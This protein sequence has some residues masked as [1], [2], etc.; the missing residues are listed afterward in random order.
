MSIHAWQHTRYVHTGCFLHT[1][2]HNIHD[3]CH[4]PTV[5][6]LKQWKYMH[7]N[8]HETCIHDVFTYTMT[9]PTRCLLY[10]FFCLATYTRRA[11]TMFLH[12]RWHNLHDV[13][14]IYFFVWQYTRYG[15]AVHDV[16][17]RDTCIHDACIH[18]VYIMCA[19]LHTRYLL[20]FF[21]FV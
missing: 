18:D 12:T 15:I 9:Q 4:F 2:W 19:C 10:I 5:H 20:H 21:I 3:A 16:Y 6:K 1:W 11:Y 7:G 13:C 17:I 14:Y 8:I